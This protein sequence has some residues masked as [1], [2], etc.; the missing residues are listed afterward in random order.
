[1]SKER[2]K[3]K[4]S[5][6][7]NMQGTLLCGGSLVVFPFCPPD[8]AAWW[9]GWFGVSIQALLVFRAKSAQVYQS[10]F[11]SFFLIWLSACILSSPALC[12]FLMCELQP[13][14]ACVAVETGRGGFPL[15]SLTQGPQPFFCERLELP[16]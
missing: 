1:M 2:M 13:R 6:N 7:K 14:N 5:S 12:P 16:F 15:E 8:L 4:T 11:C 3:V 10:C 9:G